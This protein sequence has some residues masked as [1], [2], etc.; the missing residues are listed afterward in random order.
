[1]SPLQGCDWSKLERE[2][3][4]SGA[5]TSPHEA[6]LQGSSL[7]GLHSACAV[8]HPVTELVSH[9]DESVQNFDLLHRSHHDIQEKA[10]RF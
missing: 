3:S 7:Q 6:V 8:A 1:M 2:L 5:F 9:P 4:S 10:A